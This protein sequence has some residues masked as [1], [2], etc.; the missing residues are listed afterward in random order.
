M[1]NYYFHQDNKKI[2][3]LL[4]ND[5]CHLWEDRDKDLFFAKSFFPIFELESSEI[6]LIDCDEFEDCFVPI[7][8][9]NFD[10]IHKEYGFDEL[11]TRKIKKQ[12]LRIG[13]QT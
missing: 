10:E 5:I 7:N 13:K 12:M 4:D 9:N 6:F 8:E 2:Y 11:V 3:S 1:S